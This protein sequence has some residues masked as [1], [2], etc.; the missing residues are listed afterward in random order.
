VLLL[1]FVV[2]VATV[3]SVVLAAFLRLLVYPE[4]NPMDAL[5]FGFTLKDVLTPLYL[6]GFAAVFIGII[7]KWAV[8][9]IVDI[10]NAT[11]EIAS[12]NFDVRIEEMGR[13]DEVGELQ[14]N[15]NRMARE[16]RSNEYLKKEFISNVSHEFKTPLAVIGGYAALLEKDGVPEEERKEYAQLIAKESKRLS[17]MTTNILRLSKLDNQEIKSKPTEFLLDEQIR[18]TVLLLEPKWSEK[19]IQFDIRLPGV[20]YFGDEELLSQV[21][22]NLIDNAVKYSRE[23]GLVQIALSKMDNA[24]CV[25]VRDHG[26]GM[27]EETR[28]RAFEQFYQGEASHARE[29]NGLGLSIV[30][31]IVDMHNGKV[32]VESA[33]KQGTLIS[34]WLPLNRK[35][36]QAGRRVRNPLMRI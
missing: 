18:Q 11:K 20:R 30:K 7:S 23:G 17:N 1:Y 8:G 4:T 34:V 36:D 16:L 5:M 14:R 10:S 28:L 25:F 12:G 26:I 22:V 35:Y 6:V 24:L 31:R 13:K 9:P 33:P 3:L 27:S 2:G 32:E 21:W 19:K 15:F 29:G